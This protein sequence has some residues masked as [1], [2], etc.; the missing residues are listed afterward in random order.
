MD[1]R[2]VESSNIR[3]VGYDPA[4]RAMEVQFK[5]GNHYRYKDVP[6]ESHA[7]LI[8]AESVGKHFHA[9]V[10]GKFSHEKVGP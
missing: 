5:G 2:P 1:L 6:P 9:H 7:A 8:G 10:R 3:A 4:E